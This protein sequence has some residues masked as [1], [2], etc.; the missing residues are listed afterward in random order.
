MYNSILYTGIF[1]DNY[2]FVIPIRIDSSHEKTQNHVIIFII[3]SSVRIQRIYCLS[4][5]ASTY[6]A[7]L[8]MS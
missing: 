5:N 2:N 7:L 3:K 6:I 4:S 8:V 1:S